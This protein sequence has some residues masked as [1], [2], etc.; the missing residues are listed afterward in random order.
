VFA[1][2]DT[3]IKI[4]FS[5]NVVSIVIYYMYIYYSIYIIVNY[6]Y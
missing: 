5:F 2:P 4:L 6:K 1:F 3:F